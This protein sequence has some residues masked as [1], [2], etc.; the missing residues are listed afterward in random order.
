MKYLLLAIVA[1]S[2]S[3]QV[4]GLATGSTFLCLLMSLAFGFLLGREAGYADTDD[5]RKACA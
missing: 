4:I 5:R 3:A 1:S 2:V